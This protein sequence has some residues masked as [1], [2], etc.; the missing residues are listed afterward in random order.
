MTGHEGTE[1]QV[2]GKS[3][4]PDLGAPPRPFP[5]SLEQDF[6]VPQG[7]AVR[8]PRDPCPL[9]TPG[10]VFPLISET[11]RGPSPHVMPLSLPRRFP[12]L[13]PPGRFRVRE[14]TSPFCPPQP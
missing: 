3:P 14:L 4:A 11:T 7:K 2:I 8:L 9:Q 13:R 10:L 12:V 1:S 5:L 6:L